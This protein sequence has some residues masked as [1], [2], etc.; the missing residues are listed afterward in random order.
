MT[1][2]HLNKFQYLLLSI[3]E[4][5]KTATT[6]AFSS[7][8]YSDQGFSV[9]YRTP[10]KAYCRQQSVGTRA[11]DFA[12]KDLWILTNVEMWIKCV[13][14]LKRD[15]GYYLKSFDIIPRMVG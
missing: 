13:I 1:C 6:Y 15:S 4:S 2:I 8:V 9:P 7:V 12:E 10:V 11:L 14:Q 5:T 3:L